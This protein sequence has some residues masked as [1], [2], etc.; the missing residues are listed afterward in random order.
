MEKNNFG[1]ENSVTMEKDTLHRFLIENTQV[2]GEWI[3]LDQAW[4]DI[5]NCSSYPAPLRRVLGEAA[6]AV[7]LLSA[8]IKFEGSLILQINGSGPVTMLVMQATSEGEIRGMAQWDKDHAEDLSSTDLEDLFGEGQIVISIVTDKENERYQ[9]IVGLEGESLSE[10]LQTYFEQSEQLDT[11]IHLAADDES[12]AGLL[13]QSLPDQQYDKTG[14]VVDDSWDRAVIL[15][16]TIQ[17]DELLS[18]DARELLHRLFNEDDLR[19]FE[20][21]TINYQCTCSQQKIEDMIRSIG[22]E[23][24]SSIIEEQ[25][26]IEI[27]CDFCNTHYSLDAIDVQRVFDDQISEG[28]SSLH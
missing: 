20:P 1:K 2:R 8:T 23:E 14:I 4:Q 16:N 10:C 25:K 18:L 28:N 6:A 11:R 13:I 21:Q 22:K 17:N 19:L 27:N 9:G 15:T 3:H 24:A 12:A 26:A 7:C 5:L